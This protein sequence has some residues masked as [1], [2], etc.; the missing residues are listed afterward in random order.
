M[1]LVCETGS[2]IANASRAWQAACNVDVTAWPKTNAFILST[3]ASTTVNN[4]DADFKLQWRRAGGTF[5]DV[6]ADTEIKYTT[7]T[8]LAEG[9]L[10]VANSAGC[11]ADWDSGKEAEAGVVSLVNI[12]TG[13]Y[14]EMQF[15]LA[16]GSG[17]LDEQEYEFQLVCITYSNS[18]V[19]QTTITTAAA[20]AAGSLKATE[21]H[22]FRNMMAI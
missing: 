11:Y 6:G 19:C 15:G 17:A 18:A 5:A 22:I 20:S 10:L 1:A 7:D 13:D 14:G 2:R 21:S 9:N 3:W 4:D 8:V 16:F 12:A